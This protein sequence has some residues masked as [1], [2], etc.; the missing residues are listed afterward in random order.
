MSDEV[1]IP[2]AEEADVTPPAALLADEMPF[3]AHFR[4]DH[5]PAPAIDPE[6]WSV[7]VTGAVWRPLCL[8]RPGLEALGSRTERVT[9]ECAGHRRTEHVPPVPGLAWATG[10]VGEARWTGVPLATVLELAGVAPGAQAVV[11][12]GADSGPF[13]GREGEF[14]FARAIPLAKAFARESLLAWA[15]NDEP[16][17]VRRGGP[18]RA[19]I[20]GWY[21]TDSVKWLT[22]ITV[23]DGE[24]EGPWETEDYRF[25]EPGDDGP[26]TRMTDMPIHALLVD[27]TPDAPPAAGMIALRGIAWGG[28]GGVA[29]VE[30]RVDGGP[31]RE[32]ELGPD[33]GPW[34]R[35][36]WTATRR[37]APGTRQVEV[38]AS[39]AAGNAQP[40]EPPANQCGYANNAVHRVTLEIP[41]G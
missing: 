24:F 22:R 28:I 11:L 4:R 27:P 33:R 1:A 2:L 39:D 15:V 36:F 13:C 37:A 3:A 23:I 5:Y 18:V 35:R 31:W 26:G 41:P 19:V 32:A 29:R 21:A 40:A 12:E 16:L 34:A 14:A 38:R 7:T 6:T 8:Y 30:V 17:T 9:L 25:I 20:P 10:A